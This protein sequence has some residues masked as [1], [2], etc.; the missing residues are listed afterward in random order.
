MPLVG[1]LIAA[2]LPAN[3]YGWLWCAL[4][5]AYGVLAVSDGLRRT[6]AVPGWLAAALIGASVR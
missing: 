5:L 2:R 1:A 6:D 4:G 3:P